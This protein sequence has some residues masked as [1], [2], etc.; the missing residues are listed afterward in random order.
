MSLAYQSANDASMR[1][2]QGR[3]GSLAVSRP[4]D[5][6]ESI[7][8]SDPQAVQVLTVTVSGATNDKVYTIT[9]SPE[10]AAW[11]RSVS[12][13]ADGTA[14][15]A[16]IAEGLADA[17][18]ADAY[19]RGIGEA[20]WV[21]G[22][23]F[24]VTGLHYGESFTITESDAQLS[25]ATTTAAGDAAT[26]GFGLA[27][28]DNGVGAMGSRLGRIA[29]SAQFS[30]Q[31]ATA[32]I[33]YVAGAIITAKVYEVR[34]AERI[35]IGAASETSATDL[36]TTAAAL[37]GGLNGDLPANSVVVAS[38][39]GA[40]GEITFTAEIAGLEFEV[41]LFADDSGA[42]V[43]TTT[44][45]ET[46]GPSKATSLNRALA[47]ISVGTH[48]Q[49]A[50]TI[51]GSESVYAANSLMRVASDAVVWVASSESPTFGDAVYVELDG[52]SANVGKFYTSSSS[53]RVALAKA[54]ARWSHD[55][56]TSADGIAAVEVSI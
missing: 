18:N 22:A 10:S 34:G 25:V 45:A 55:G 15:T 47:G 2:R 28:L 7:C 31:V 37:A 33:T 39:G 35:L 54:K 29:K 12:Y 44:V 43:P 26:I 38:V 19:L 27:V 3:V 4:G 20:S 56:I 52:S 46:T 51:A 42:S 1:A 17:W 23:T 48:D 11:S 49:T 24:T 8:N 30:A 21:S 6:V 5:R 14:T 53:T 9:G 13:T 50:T 41:E 36:D 16:E 40:S 32:T